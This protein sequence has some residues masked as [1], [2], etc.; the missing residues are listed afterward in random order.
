[1][2]G[3]LCSTP[4]IPAP[5][6][7]TELLSEGPAPRRSY[8]YLFTVCSSSSLFFLP[9]RL[10]PAVTA[11]C[12]R[13]AA[14]L[15]GRSQVAAGLGAE[16]AA[17]RARGTGIWSPGF[18]W[19]LSATIP[20]ESPHPSSWLGICSLP[21]PAPLLQPREKN[22]LGIPATALSRD[23]EGASCWLGRENT[24]WGKSTVYQTPQQTHMI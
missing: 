19:A 24:C 14:P 23:G 9:A 17:R 1:M 22:R 7:A 3:L 15:G 20:A 21:H 6:L 10:Q 5:P 12:S 4:T 16:D 8:F 18:Q 13:T 2:A 11:F